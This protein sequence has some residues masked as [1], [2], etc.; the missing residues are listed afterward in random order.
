MIHVAV[1]FLHEIQLFSP[2]SDLSFGVS[3]VVLGQGNGFLFLKTDFVCK[4]NRFWLMFPLETTLFDFYDLDF[5]E[6][7]CCQ[8]SGE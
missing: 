6:K 8:V 2:D 4:F 3:L 5:E 7:V 1:G